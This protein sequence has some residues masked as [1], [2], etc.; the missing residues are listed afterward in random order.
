MTI[1]KLHIKGFYEYLVSNEK[2]SAT[3]EKYIR[4]VDAFNR[5]L[6]GRSLDKFRVLE[7]KAHICERYAISSVNSII[8]SLNSYFN[9]LEW[10]G[11]KVK[12]LKVQKQIFVCKE[13]ELSKKEYEVLLESAKKQGKIRLYFLMQTICATGIR[14]S[15]LRFVTVEAL[16]AGFAEIFCK[17]KVRTV[18]LPTELCTM[19][20]KYTAKQKIISGPVFVSKNGNPLNRSNIWHDMK[21][22]CSS[23]GVSEV[24][25][26]PHNLRHLFARS[27]YSAQKD[28]V[29]LA[30]ILGHS[31]VNTTRIY[32]MESGDVHRKQIQ[33]LGL[34]KGETT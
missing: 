32:I 16:D 29:R 8:S 6:F 3:I 33:S 19:L 31:N 34:I 28:I 30:D 15:E 11:L 12:T 24:K 4:D 7:Y 27:Y 2:S 21:S 18:I 22:I 13:Q 25:V 10:Y 9:Y 1:D 20:K 17:G 23:A 5:W 14:I 26:F